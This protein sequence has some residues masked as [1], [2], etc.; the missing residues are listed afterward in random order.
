MYDSP[1][2]IQSF[3]EFSE[4][5][6][7]L[8]VCWD[9]YLTKKKVPSGLRSLISSSWKRCERMRVSP[10]Q[11]Q[12]QVV[13][14]QYDLLQ[15]KVE[16]KLLLEVAMP[17]MEEI[18][19]HFPTEKIISAVLTDA[20]GVI[21]EIKANQKSLSTAESHTFFQGADWTE[22]SAGTNAIGTAL[23]TGQPTQVFGAEH[24]CWAW[25]PWVCSAVPIRDPLTNKILGIL[26]ISGEKGLVLAHDL[27]YLV[28]QVGKIEHNLTLHL[29][30][31]NALTLQTLTDSMG[32]PFVVIDVNG[33]VKR[34]N[35]PAKMMLDLKEESILFN[36]LEWAA[37]P[38]EWRERLS[39]IFEEKLRSRNG[40][41]WVAKFYPY[42][43][44]GK[45]FGSMVLF[46]KEWS[47][48]IQTS[49]GHVA[50]FHF[51]DLVTQHPSMLN[52]IEVA[53]KAAFS[54]QTVLITGETGTGKEVLAQAI[55]NHGSRREGPFVAVNCG[56]IP[57][58][59]LASELFGYEKGAFTGAN[60]Q[61]KKG[62]FLLAD[63]G[64]I[65]LDEIGDLP[66]KVQTYLLRV[67]EERMVHPLGRE[68]P[69]PVDVRVIAATHKDLEQE[70]RKGNFREDLYFR[71]KVIHFQL[72]PLRRRK[73]DL[74]LLVD[75]MV[76][77]LTKGKRKP[78]VDPAAM[79]V[80][81]AYHWPGNLRELRNVLDRALFYAENRIGLEHLPKEIVEQARDRE[82]VWIMSSW[83]EKRE[84]LDEREK[85]LWALEATRWNI[86]QT[87]RILNVSRMTVYRWMKRYGL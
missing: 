19:L 6:K 60:R 61:G 18:F 86:T 36:I 26:D 55:H 40:T 58:E 64:T 23:A 65:L 32:D 14:D 62:K 1:L 74:P 30:Q 12:V 57:E 44:A 37:D 27:Y 81:E 13:S 79:R 68:R 85:L 3:A 56:A 71:L 9:D 22:G 33:T 46:K 67:L 4:R 75:R 83:K 77:Q 63:K 72:P 53:K 31:E 84:P 59:L 29:T 70:L 25:H 38:L 73:Q 87:A 39:N 20:C 82:A 35:V 34:S 80:L 5:E 7:Q 49:V 50:R 24:F 69:I 43:I 45:L 66:L 28:S 41:A 47:Q 10:L 78:S 54:D 15:K 42:K 17:F 51:S 2:A 76:A 48:R 21:I 11:T 8:L 52:L 16:N